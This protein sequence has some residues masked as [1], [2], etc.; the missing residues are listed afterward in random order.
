MKVL[1]ALLLVIVCINAKTYNDIIKCYG[2]KKCDE[3]RADIDK[4]FEL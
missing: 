4:D 3:K 2:E 1:I